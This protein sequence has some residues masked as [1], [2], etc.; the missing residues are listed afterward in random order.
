MHAVA[1]QA[2]SMKKFRKIDIKI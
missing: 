2:K 1:L